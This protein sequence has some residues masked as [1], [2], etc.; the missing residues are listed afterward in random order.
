MDEKFFF[1]LH[2]YFYL[3]VEEVFKL[4]L[5]FWKKDFFVFEEP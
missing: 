5:F 3:G 1:C 2:V 4:Q